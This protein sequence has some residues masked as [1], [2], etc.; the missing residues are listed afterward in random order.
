MC[1][2]NNSESHMAEPQRQNQ[3]WFFFFVKASCIREPIPPG[4]MPRTL[5]KSSVEKSESFSIRQTPC[6]LGD[7][8]QTVLCTLWK[9]DRRRV[10]RCG[11]TKEESVKVR[12]QSS[13]TSEASWVLF[14]H[15][16]WGCGGTPGGGLG[17]S[18]S[19]RQFLCAEMPTAWPN[20]VVLL[21][22]TTRLLTCLEWGRGCLLIPAEAVCQASSSLSGLHQLRGP[23]WR[24]SLPVAVIGTT[25]HLVSPAPPV[26]PCVLLRT[27]LW[28]LW[29]LS[30]KSM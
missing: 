5:T 6:L 3:I 20:S 14:H 9:K 21:F 27:V 1:V 17:T 23:T 22:E 12:W 24:L 13:P 18:R 4:R 8:M 2:G 26:G 30:R 29:S 11:V 25:E 7:V 28:S 16:K 19:P 10:G 15:L